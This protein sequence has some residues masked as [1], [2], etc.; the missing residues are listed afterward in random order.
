MSKLGILTAVFSGVLMAGMGS[1]SALAAP[2]GKHGGYVRPA[3]PVAA[4][5]YVRP[6]S[7]HHPR[8]GY[9][10]PPGAYYHPDWDDDWRF[11]LYL[12]PYSFYPGYYPSPYYYPPYY[13]PP[14]VVTV[15]TT[16]PEY[17]EREEDSA[18]PPS[19]YWY[20][21][22]DPKGYYP[23]VQRCNVE[24]QPVAPKPPQAPPAEGE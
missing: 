4:R 5:S 17:I 7:Y 12:S 8:G 15:P 10:R 3:P 23:E 1:S 22:M 16:P 24:W 9:Y 6:D 20:Y 2:P 18:L 14:A 11:S 13:Y 21:C 19:A